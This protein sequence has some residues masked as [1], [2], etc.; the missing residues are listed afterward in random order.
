MALSGAGSAGKSWRRQVV[1]LV[2]VAVG[3]LLLGSLAVMMLAPAAKMPQVS[4]VIV[5]H[6]RQAARL[7]QLDHRPRTPFDPTDAD[8][9]EDA[10]EWDAAEAEGYHWAEDEGVTDAKACERLAEAAPFRSGC[11]EAVDDGR[12]DAEVWPTAGNNRHC[13]SAMIGRSTR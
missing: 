7:K 11:A 5:F 4:R 3:G 13:K 9:A 6:I 8:A 1:A 10:A 2:A 12:P